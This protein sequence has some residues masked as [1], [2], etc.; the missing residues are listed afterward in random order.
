MQYDLSFVVVFALVT[1]DS[2][3]L[4]IFS[5][6]QYVCIGLSEKERRFFFS[7]D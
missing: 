5:G 4:R 7:S 2:C 3:G 1:L 6:L